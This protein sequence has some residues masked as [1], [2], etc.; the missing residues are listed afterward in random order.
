VSLLLV[1][2]SGC[3]DPIES[4]TLTPGDGTV[5]G[6]VRRL[7]QGRPPLAGAQVS[8]DGAVRAHTD[9]NG[10]YRIGGVSADRVHTMAADLAGYVHTEV[11]VSVTPSGEQLQDFGLETPGD[12]SKQ[13]LL[14][15][16]FVIDDSAGMASRQ[17]AL[18]AAFARLADLLVQKNLNLHLGIVTADVGAGPTA[19]PGCVPGGDR[20]LLQ[21]QPLGSTCDRAALVPYTGD[22]Y[23]G[24]V[25]DGASTV[26]ANFEG[27]LADAF[28][29]YA[30][31][32]TA[33]CQFQMPL[34]AMA[35]AIDPTFT[36][37]GDFLRDGATLLVVI[38]TDKDDCSAPTDTA[39]F[40]PFQTDPSSVLGPLSSFRCFEFG[41]T[42]EGLP[43]GRL[44]G[45]RTDCRP[46]DPDPRY[47]L[48]PIA[49]FA[50]ALAAR[51]ENRVVLGVLAGPASPVKVTLDGEGDARLVPYCF[52][53]GQGADPAI[54]LATLAESMP[55][56][57]VP[58]CAARDY[59]AALESWAQQALVLGR[60]CEE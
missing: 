60:S 32:G 56:S 1:L 45:T 10:A 25:S 54:R 31:V 35:R 17:A 57:S 33:G 58:V 24:M 27:S 13:T 40:D 15:V 19:L 34:A 14:D 30:P 4:G 9:E 46:G 52:V 29:C 3:L 6:S 37:N 18:A 11:L 7:C 51:H 38:V 21:L 20:G 42:C 39:L 23:L 41:V 16:L 2:L 59:A 5:Y 8:I 49:D 28:A 43:P 47:T 50:A 36:D 12:A 53:D 26:S 55:T 48:T 44:A 22:R